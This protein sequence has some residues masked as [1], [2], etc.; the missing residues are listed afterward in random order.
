MHAATAASVGV[1]MPNDMPPMMIAGVISAGSAWTKV[2]RRTESRK[3][4]SRPILWRW[5]YQVTYI[6]R[7]AAISRPGMKPAA[8]SWPIET[9]AMTPKMTIGSDGGMMGPMVAEAAVTPTAKSV[10]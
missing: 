3:T 6:M 1:K 9:F 7:N 8:K 2:V 4:W 5:A 10:L